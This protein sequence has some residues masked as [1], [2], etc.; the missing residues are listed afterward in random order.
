MLQIGFEPRQ[1][2]AEF[3]AAVTNRIEVGA[4]TLRFG[5]KSQETLA[6]LLGFRLQ[7]GSARLKLLLLGLELQGA[8]A[9]QSVLLLALQLFGAGGFDLA[10][11]LGI[12]ILR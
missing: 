8:L 10:L 2:I 1:R 5:I 6:H 9:Q 7:F 11:E 3:G 12:A 4:R